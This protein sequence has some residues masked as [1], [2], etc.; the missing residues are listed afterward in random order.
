M[1]GRLKPGDGALTLYI[2][3]SDVQAFYE[4]VK[5]ELKPASEL[6]T[7][8]YGATEFSVQDPDGYLLF[9]AQHD[10]ERA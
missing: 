5:S 4:R 1:L 8:D 7:T 3:V 6:S 2:S 9:F 10:E